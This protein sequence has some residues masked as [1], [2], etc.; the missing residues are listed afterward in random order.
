MDILLY[1]AS[2]L[3]YAKLIWCRF[4]S[5]AYNDLYVCVWCLQ[6]FLR[7]EDIAIS[8]FSTLIALPWDFFTITQWINFFW[9]TYAYGIYQLMLNRIVWKSYAT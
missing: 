3:K 8:S 7:M 6:L 4:A 2:D 9:L 5:P 1:Y